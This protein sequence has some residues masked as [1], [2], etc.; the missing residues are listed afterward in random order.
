[1]SEKAVSQPWVLILAGAGAT[2]AG[3]DRLTANGAGELLKAC[4]QTAL[5]ATRSEQIFVL[6]SEDLE[7]FVL[8]WTPGLA[9]ENLILEP[10]ARGTGPA[11]VLAMVQIALAGASTHDPVL[12]LRA[13]VVV[14]DEAS[15]QASLGR[16]VEACLEHAALVALSSTASGLENSY[17]WLGLGAPEEVA[18]RGAG[19]SGEVIRVLQVKVDPGPTEA[20]QYRDSGKWRWATG[21]L[22]FRHGYMGY[23]LGEVCDE[24]DVAM[25]LAGCLQQADMSALAAE[26]ALMP[27]LS[28][29]ESVLAG[30]PRVLS[31]EL[32][33]GWQR[34]RSW[35]G[36]ALPEA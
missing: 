2:T 1:M 36:P 12:V 5:G 13:D 16:A 27:A 21:M 29:E 26:Y 3:P 33:C 17:G 8:E 20:A 19:D 10:S 25:L 18:D 31:I 32:G 34:A 30:A 9:V 24:F 11:M 22:A 14:D 35:S 15:L 23:I 7:A 28:F 6:C 4:W